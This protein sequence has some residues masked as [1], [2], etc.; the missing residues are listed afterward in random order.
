MST[1]KNKCRFSHTKHDHR[2]IQLRKDEGKLENYQIDGVAYYVQ[3][4]EEAHKLFTQRE[5]PHRMCGLTRELIH[6]GDPITLVAN[7]FVAFPNKIVL[8]SAFQERG[9]EESIR[10][11][12]QRYDR[13]LAFK[14]EFREW[15]E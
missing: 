5:K 15:V 8:T 6:T 12:K 13:Y 2:L 4:L 10:Y 3:H 7:N 14:N 1:A 9:A 11:L